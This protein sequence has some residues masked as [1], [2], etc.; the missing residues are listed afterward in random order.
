MQ[1]WAFYDW[2]NSVYSLVITSTIFPIYYTAVTA[3]E[4]SDLVS[5]F[6]WEVRNTV[7][8]SYSLSAAFLLI[9]LLLPVLSGIADYGGRKKHFMKF[10]VYL[11]SAACASLFFFTGENVEFGLIAFM[12]AAIG[13]IGSL[14]FY[15]AY[16][17]EIATS[18]RFDRLSARGYALGYAGS[19]LL[20]L[21][22]LS[23]VLFPEAYSITDDSFPAR[24]S[25]LLTGLWWAG[26]AQLTFRV[27]PNQDFGKRNLRSSIGK[28]LQELKKVVRQLPALPSLLLFLLAFFA[29]SM[30][31]QT[32]MYMATLFGD[33][34]LQMESSMLIITILTIQIVAIGGAFLFAWLSKKFGNVAALMIAVLIWV[35]V[36]AG[37]YFTYT[38]EQFIG[39]AV[40]VGL[41]MGGIQSLSRSTY[42][43]LLPPSRDHASYFSFY[44]VTEKVAIVIGTASYGLIENITGSMRNSVFV[45]MIFFL[46]GLLLLVLV[47]RKRDVA[48][49]HS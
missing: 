9:S 41:V 47:Q 27:L 1:G 8:Y 49:T 23:M 45:L 39:L 7:V 15:N 46:I 36:C 19:V 20:L 33:K 26:F 43:K 48:L 44:E 21:F 12:L 40:V 17:P 4:T 6:G 16:L 38:A 18:D 11:G 42:S 5:I 32:V 31:V 13:F 34:E 3:S 2:A 30:G 14:V 29:Y 22:N 28:G 35:L 37:A 10:F 25:F 24:F